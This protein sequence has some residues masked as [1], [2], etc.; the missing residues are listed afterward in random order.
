MILLK[1]SSM[2]MSSEGFFSWSITFGQK[3]PRF[4]ENSQL[5]YKNL[6][7]NVYLMILEATKE[8]SLIGRKKKL[9]FSAAWTIWFSATK[10]SDVLGKN[11][12]SF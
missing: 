2:G 9:L 8:E 1:E 12:S 7:F 10:Y 6:P 3:K 11:E 5:A 4:S